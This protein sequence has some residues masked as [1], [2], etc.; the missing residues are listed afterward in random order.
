ML[1]YKLISKKPIVKK[2]NGDESY[3][4]LLPST[5]DG[6]V[7]MRAIPII[8]SKY[9]VARPDLISLS[10][11]GDDKYGDIICKL[12]GISNPFELNEDMILILPD[13]EYLQ[14][15]VL[16]TV[17]P[18]ELVKDPKSDSIYQSNEFNMQKKKNEDRSPNQQLIGESNYVIDKSLGII[19]Y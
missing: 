2:D 17:N 5:Y 9:Y 19:F 18:S 10:M 15:C 1:D 16:K 14:R 7:G 12:N 6:N 13:I 4:D 8:V 11:Y 3:I